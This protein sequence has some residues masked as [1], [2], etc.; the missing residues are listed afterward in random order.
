M[1]EPNLLQ[2]GGETVSDKA[3]TYEAL[4]ERWSCSVSTLYAMVRRGELKT[5]RIGRATRIS[6][7]EVARIERGEETESK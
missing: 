1:E 7:T 2:E 5:F 4:A 3:L 6:A